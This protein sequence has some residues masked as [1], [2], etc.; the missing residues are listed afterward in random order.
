M[1]VHEVRWKY[2]NITSLKWYNLITPHYKLTTLKVI[3]KLTNNRQH[4]YSFYLTIKQRTDV[5][6]V[7]SHLV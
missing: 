1:W 4:W 7:F 3:I 6:T 5:V 2:N